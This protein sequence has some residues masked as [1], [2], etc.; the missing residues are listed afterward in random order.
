MIGDP[1]DERKEIR[2]AI[3]MYVD[4]VLDMVPLDAGERFESP[5]RNVRLE[6][7]KSQARQLVE[8]LTKQLDLPGSVIFQVKG[9][10]TI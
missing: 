10:L 7:T 3:I 2:R 1:K 8:Q 5:Q 4:E 6:L 9:H